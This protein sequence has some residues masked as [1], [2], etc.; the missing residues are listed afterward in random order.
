MAT[1]SLC[2]IVKNESEVLARA[3]GNARMY[4]DEIIIADTGSSDNTV[5]IAKKYADAVYDFEWAD[6][7]SAA[8]NFVA[9]KATG[10]YWMW[11]DADDIVPD[12]AAAA[13]GRLMRK[14]SPSVDIVMLPYVLGLDER[15]KPLYSYYRE[16]I[17]KNRNGYFWSGRV[18]EA[19]ALRGK[20]IRAAPSV[21]HAKP[22][23]RRTGSRNLDIYKSMIAEGVELCPRERY[24]YARE[25]FFNDEIGAAAGE[26]KRFLE[27]PNG[28]AANKTDACLMLS[29]CYGRLGD[30]RR[31]FGA[32]FDSFMYGLPTGEACCEIALLF[33]AGNDYKCAAYWFERAAAAKPDISTGA[34]VDHDY[35]G[36]IPYVWLAVCYDRL[37]NTRR[38]YRYH[39][40]ARK[41]RPNHP[42]VIYNQTYFEKLGY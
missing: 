1:L 21:L 32:L 5:E 28:L 18:H 36:F 2:M 19:I 12:D 39:C 30:K 42:S 14:L 40:R 10:D 24:Y 3:L 15:G 4:A 16:R 34:F 35:Y 11:L 9:S 20:V 17:I 37:G 26:F 38:A 13:I 41:L 33:F 22:S 7:F 25:L 31:A 8:R 6:D 27:E 23:T 29:R